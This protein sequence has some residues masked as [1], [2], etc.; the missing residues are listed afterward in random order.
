R[1]HRLR[2]V[3]RC[4]RAAARLAGGPGGM[5]EPSDL[6]G[7]AR[8]LRRP[9]KTLEAFAHLAPEEIAILSRAIDAAFDRERAR[10]D[11]AL[12]RAIAGWLRPLARRILGSR[13]A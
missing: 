7:L 1:R 13:R 6:E 12:D 8:R 9:V 2:A 4:A 10:I 5:S 3:D 11:E